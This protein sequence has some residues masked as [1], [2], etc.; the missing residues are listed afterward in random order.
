VTP[1]F[2]SA[3]SGLRAAYIYRRAFMYPFGR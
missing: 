1:D 2:A 3:Q